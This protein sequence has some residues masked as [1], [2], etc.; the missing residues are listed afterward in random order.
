MNVLPE[1]TSLASFF[2]TTAVMCV[3]TFGLV[4][5]L[6]NAENLTYRGY[7][8]WTAGLQ[9]EMQKDASETWNTRGVRLHNAERNQRIGTPVSNWWYL[10]YVF[11]RMFRWGR[12]QSRRGGDEGIETGPNSSA[13]GNM[14]VGEP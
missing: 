9:E 2:V 7:R 8:R 4:F 10:G 1:S 5:N 6:R 14:Y 3:V 11:R 12:P 13:R